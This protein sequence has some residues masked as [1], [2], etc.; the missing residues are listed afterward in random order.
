MAETKRGRLGVES[1]TKATNTTVYSVT[2][3]MT[4]LVDVTFSNNSTTNTFVDLA[5]VDGLAADIVA[6]DYIAKRRSVPYG[7]SITIKDIQMSDDESVVASSID[8]NVTVRVSG[9]EED[10][11]G[12]GRVQELIVSGVVAAGTESV[13]LNHATVIVAATIADLNLHQGFLMIKDTSATGVVAHTIT[14]AIGTF[15]GTND[16]LTFNALNDAILLY[17]D[18]AGNGT[19]IEN[20]GSV[21]PSAT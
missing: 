7:E 8:S 2:D 18:S 5:I 16:I 4:A 21:V 13:E 15:D 20:V 17:I 3:S 9:V 12:Q 19:I 6:E 11:A 14:A 10:A 1:L